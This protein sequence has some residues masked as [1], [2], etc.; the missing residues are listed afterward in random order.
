MTSRRAPS[1]S[2]QGR[3]PMQPNLVHRDV[4]FRQGS[5]R[6]YETQVWMTSCTTTMRLSLGSPRD[7]LSFTHSPRSRL[8]ASPDCL[9]PTIREP[10]DQACPS[11][12]HCRVLH[13]AMT[14]PACCTRLF[15]TH[16]ARDLPDATFVPCSWTPRH[17][18]FQRCP[19][20]FHSSARPSVLN[21][22]LLFP[23]PDSSGCIADHRPQTHA[24]HDD[25]SPTIKPGPL[26]PAPSSKSSSRLVCH[27]PLGDLSHWARFLSHLD[28]T[29]RVRATGHAC[30]PPFP[31]SNATDAELTPLLNSCL[32]CSLSQRPC[33]ARRPAQSS[34]AWP[35]L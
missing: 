26:R 3:M 4:R 21:H 19:F 35:W 30:L 1:P 27:R 6:S 13:S 8:P 11:A 20:F 31:S 24:P 29:Q 18:Q 23:L 5:R 33:L 25:H 34:S 7:R 14:D 12:E 10:W 16:L 9:D 28:D 22:N 2:L 32:G 17:Q 15:V